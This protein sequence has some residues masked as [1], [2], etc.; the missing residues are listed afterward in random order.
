M[1]MLQMVPFSIWFW[2]LYFSILFFLHWNKLS[3][4]RNWPMLWMPCEMCFTIYQWIKL[5]CSWHDV[6][7]FCLFFAFN[8]SMHTYLD[9]WG[10]KLTM[11]SAV[12]FFFLRHSIKFQFYQCNWNSIRLQSFRQLIIKCILQHSFEMIFIG[13]YFKFV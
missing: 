7:R 9:G 4:K 11:I 13:F 6:E 10:D 12:V 8:A 3:I 1:F 5:F 2:F